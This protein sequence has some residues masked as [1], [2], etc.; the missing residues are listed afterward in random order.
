MNPRDFCNVAQQLAGG[1][2]PA[3]LRTA[4]GRAYYALFNVGAELIDPIVPV[5][6]GPA[7]HGQIIRLL[8]NCSDADVKAVG[9]GLG[10]LHSRRGGTTNKQTRR[11]VQ[12]R[13]CPVGQEVDPGPLDQH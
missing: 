4:A 7:G 9:R 8:Q 3:Q 10:M 6:R 12:R 2:D 5:N 11:G 13:E 1:N